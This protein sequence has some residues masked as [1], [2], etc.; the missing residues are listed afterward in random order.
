[1]VVTANALF[2]T[3]PSH[4]RQAIFS[5]IP[6]LSNHIPYYH[7]SAPSYQKYF[8]MFPDECFNTQKVV[9]H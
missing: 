8:L 6:L 5:K 2:V 3:L 7:D 1:M 4:T 9:I